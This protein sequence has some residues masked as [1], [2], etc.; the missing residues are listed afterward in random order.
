MQSSSN[1]ED[2]ESIWWQPSMVLFGRLSGWI[3]G[4]IIIALFL[5]KWLD[6]KYDSEP[7]LF[8]STVG[9]A[10]VVSSIGIVKEATEAMKKMERQERISRA[11]KK[12]SK[13]L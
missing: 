3:S 5:G 6:E 8:L 7:W 12:K 1:N 13:F 4:P 10:F 2:K 11:K 9:A